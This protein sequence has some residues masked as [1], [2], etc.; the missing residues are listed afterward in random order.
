MWFAAA[1][2]NARVGGW[3]KCMNKNV[4]VSIFIT[5]LTYTV[6]TFVTTCYN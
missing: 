4:N 1:I 2:M 3:G 5:L 6:F